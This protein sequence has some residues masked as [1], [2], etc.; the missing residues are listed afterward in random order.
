MT[1]NVLTVNLSLYAADLTAYGDYTFVEHILRD[2]KKGFIG[3]MPSFS[4]A[5]FNK[6]QIEALAAY[7]NSLKVRD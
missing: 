1:Q 3:K 6:T 7:I 5:N 2:G 4:Y